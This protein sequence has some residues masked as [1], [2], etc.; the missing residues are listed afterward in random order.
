MNNTYLKINLSYRAKRRSVTAELAEHRL[1]AL[2]KFTTLKGNKLVNI[3][4][5]NA[6][7]TKTHL[8]ILYMFPRGDT[9]L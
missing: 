6:A 5:C 2:P 9:I 8:H 1:V 3:L 4:N 7:N